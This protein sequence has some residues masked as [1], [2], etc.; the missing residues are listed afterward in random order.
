MD[1]AACNIEQEMRWSYQRIEN[2]KQVTK[3]KMSQSLVRSL[4]AETKR[5]DI[6]S[7]LYEISILC[8]CFSVTII[9]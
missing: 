6:R 8:C 9:C 4:K 5:V 7:A 3:Q 2:L 1:I